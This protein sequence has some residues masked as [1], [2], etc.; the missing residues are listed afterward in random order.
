MEK[1]IKINEENLDILKKDLSLK[2]EAI[3]SMKS[4]KTLLE[5]QCNDMRAFIIKHCTPDEKEKFKNS[6]LY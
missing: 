6:G 1:K 4:Q 5:Q 3:S 2:D